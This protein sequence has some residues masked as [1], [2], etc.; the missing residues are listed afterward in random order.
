MSGS[1]VYGDVERMANLALKEKIAQNHQRI[2]LPINDSP[3][4][5]ALNIDFTASFEE[6]IKYRPILHSDIMLLDEIIFDEEKLQPLYDTIVFL[7]AKGEE[8]LVDVSGIFYIMSVFLPFESWVKAT[9]DNLIA[10][11]N[12]VEEI[13]H[14]LQN[15]YLKLDEAGADY[16]CMADGISTMSIVGKKFYQKNCGPALANLISI[17]EAFK[18][19]RLLICPKTFTSLKC[20]GALEENKDGKIHLT[21]CSITTKDASVGKPHQLIL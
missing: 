7:K 5:R 16:I 6:G 11:H 14:I 18:Y 20:F 13:T 3:L 4:L 17:Q 15:Y 21:N 2:K 10:F 9:K 12:L 19:A 1:A 8:I